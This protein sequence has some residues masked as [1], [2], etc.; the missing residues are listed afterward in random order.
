MSQ[1]KKR[2]SMSIDPVLFETLTSF[3][4]QEKRSI[5]NAAEVAIEEFLKNHYEGSDNNAKK[6]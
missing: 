1:K 2:I 3:C 6:S 4:K 5:S